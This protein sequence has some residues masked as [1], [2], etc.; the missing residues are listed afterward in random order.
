MNKSQRLLVVAALVVI[1]A[2]LSF[3]MLDWHDGWRP[4]SPVL[5]FYE[6]PRGV[7]NSKNYWGLYTRF[8]VAGIM[9]GIVVPLCLVATAAFI[10]LGIKTR[11]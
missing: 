11:S 4:G 9:L 1:G 3:L 8:G 2:V 10:A 7:G 6:Q 5:I